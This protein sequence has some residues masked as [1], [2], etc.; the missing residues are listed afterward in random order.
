MQ[1]KYPMIIRE[2]VGIAGLLVAF[3]TP[4]ANI[5]WKVF[6]AL[7]CGNTVVL[8]PSEDIP[9]TSWF[10]NKL[11][12]ESSLPAGV[13]NTVYGLGL[14]AG[15]ALVRHPMINLISF[16]GSTVVGKNIAKVA[17][18]RLA[19]VF[20]ELGGKNPLVVCDDADLSN[21][22]KWVVLSAFSNAGQ[23]CAACSRV[24]ILDSVY[25]KFKAE[26]LE[27]TAK[28]KVGNTNDDDFGPIINAKQRNSILQ[29]VEKAKSEGSTVIHGGTP[30]VKEGAAGGFYMTPTIVENVTPQQDISNNELFGPVVNLYRVNNFAEA[31]T[32]ANNSPFGLTACIHTRDINKATEFT[33]RV[34][35]GVAIINGG[36]YGSEPNMPF[37][38]VKNSGNGWREPGTEALDIYSNLKNIITLTYPEKI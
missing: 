14:E 24:I 27:R 5:A 33:R 34:Q 31:L 12:I 16:T 13:F 29:A 37:G 26:L 10:F 23:R 11:V 8:K 21:A 4:I 20:L 36:T 18:E 38:G 28:L 15:D 25:D 19:K 1:N 3:N 9:L 30:L 22:A 6:P 32:L 2:P 35:S 17:G 7:I